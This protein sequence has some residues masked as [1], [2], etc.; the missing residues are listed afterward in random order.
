MVEAWKVILQLHHEP[1]ALVFSRQAMPTFDRTKYAS[2]G[3]RGKGAYILADAAD[4]KPEVILMGTGSEVSLC[5]SAYEQLKAEGVK[6]RVVSMPSWNLFE[7]QSDDYK[8][9]VLPPDVKAR[10][11]VEQ[12]A[13][14]GWSKYVGRTGIVIGMRGSAP[15]RQSRTCRRSSGSR[16][17]TSSRRPERQWESRI[18]SRQ[19]SVASLQQTA[20]VHGMLKTDD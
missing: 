2:G 18:I 5:M 8:A 15:R 9:E 7:H 11:A 16:R 17:K 10:V 6:A 19:S 4:G 14:F 13:T 20:S 12:A 3:R 1:A